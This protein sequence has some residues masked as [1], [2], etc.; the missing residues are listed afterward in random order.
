MSRSYK[1]TT[2]KVAVAPPFQRIPPLEPKVGVI[3]LSFR[4]VNE[5]KAYAIQSRYHEAGTR[6]PAYSAQSLAESLRLVSDD[7]KRQIIVADDGFEQKQLIANRGHV[8]QC[9]DRVFQVV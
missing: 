6:P 2:Q 9:G 8:P 3:G 7:K 4:G 1:H 5:R